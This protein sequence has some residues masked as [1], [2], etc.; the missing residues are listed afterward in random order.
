MTISTTH[1]QFLK[2]IETTQ[3]NSLKIWGTENYP[4]L[5]DFLAG[6]KYLEKLNVENFNFGLFIRNTDVEKLKWI[7]FPIKSLRLDNNFDSI[8]DS[9]AKLLVFLSKFT[10]ILEKVI[11]YRKF[12]D[13]VY[14]MIFKKFI[15]LKTL[16]FRLNEMPTEDHLY[17][18]LQPNYSVR[19]L[20]VNGLYEETKYL[21]IFQG[22]LGNL[23]NVE[24]LNLT[25]SANVSQEL[26]A[27]VSNNIRN[28]KK[29]IIGEFTNNMFDGVNIP[30]LKSITIKDPEDCIRTDWAAMID[31]L[32]NIEYFSVSNRFID[33]TEYHQMFRVISAGWTHL[34]HIKL[35]NHRVG[36]Q[37]KELL[38]KCNELKTVEIDK[39]SFDKTRLDLKEEVL[40]ISKQNGIRFIIY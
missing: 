38:T 30:S 34:R 40:R 32:P 17:H 29:L 24:T 37:F 26:M 22:L 9:E 16:F 20:G 8:L 2:L 19:T 7:H 39:W 14:E 18:N 5:V 23:P 10:G 6:Q 15:K 35:S 12:P 3:L 1:S 27:F 33:E 25:G 13:S 31:G 4:C 36:E 21:K 11:L 28:L